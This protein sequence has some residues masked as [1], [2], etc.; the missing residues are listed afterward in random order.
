MPQSVTQI[1]DLRVCRCALELRL[2][3]HLVGLASRK[4]R[5]WSFIYKAAVLER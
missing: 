2:F 1:S 4:Q 5:N 3:F